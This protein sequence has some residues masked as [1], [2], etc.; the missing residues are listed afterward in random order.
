MR[1]RAFCGVSPC[2]A[3]LRRLKKQQRKSAGRC[4]ASPRKRGKRAAAPCRNAK[5]EQGRSALAKKCKLFVSGTVRASASARI[6]CVEFRHASPARL[7]IRQTLSAHLKKKT[8]HSA[9]CATR[10]A[11]IQ[12]CCSKKG[13]PIG[14]RV[15]V[16]MSHIFPACTHA[17]ARIGRRLFCDQYA[18]PRARIDPDL[19]QFPPA[20]TSVRQGFGGFVCG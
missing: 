11:R 19:T 7:R 10:P 4:G 2:A 20:H 13:F 16:Y 6:T 1:T 14:T 12:T 8:H 5:T 17:R 3:P 18:R 15:R 9:T